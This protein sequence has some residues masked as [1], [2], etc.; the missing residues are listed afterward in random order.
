MRQKKAIAIIDAKFGNLASVRNAFAKI[1]EKTIVVSKPAEI[2]K[3]G[4]LVLPG[5]G[6]FGSAMQMLE[7]KKLDSAIKEFISSGKPFLGI[8]IGMQLLF[9]ESEESSGKKGLCL[10]RGQV[11]KFT[12]VKTPQ[13]GWNRIYP[14][15]QTRLL[16]GIVNGEFVFFANS[17]YT[18]PLEEEIVAAKA[19]YGQSFCAAIESGNVFA[20][21]FHPEKSGKTG[22]KILKNFAEAE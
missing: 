22:L 7:A 18:K 13:I 5:V 10:F 4:R 19:G 14:T 2:E 15:K 9:E 21:Q 11:K 1:G 20:T 3:A 17:Y 16:S 6:A 12:G 8:C